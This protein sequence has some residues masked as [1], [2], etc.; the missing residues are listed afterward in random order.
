MAAFRPQRRT[1]PDQVQVQL[2]DLKLT[3]EFWTSTVRFCGGPLGTV[4]QKKTHFVQHKA[5]QTHEIEELKQL[6]NHRRPLLL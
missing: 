2:R 6:V 3:F 4:E 5:K 1:I